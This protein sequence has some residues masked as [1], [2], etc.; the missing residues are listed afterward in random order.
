MRSSHNYLPLSFSTIMEDMVPNH[1]NETLFTSLQ[2]GSSSTNLLHST[3]HLCTLSSTR[4]EPHL[5]HK[6]IKL[7]E[8]L[9]DLT[10]CTFQEV[11]LG[12]Y[13][14]GNLTNET[15]RNLLT[16]R[17][18]LLVWSHLPSVGIELVTFYLKDNAL[19]L[20]LMNSSPF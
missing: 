9:L 6:L 4:P 3:M 16:Y 12:F 17:S 20:G 2:R 19:P 18:L 11:N 5:S 15:L 8:T 1:A 10:M 7:I 14:T 13:H